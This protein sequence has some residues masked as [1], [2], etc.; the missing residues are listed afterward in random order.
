MSEMIERVA[1][2]LFDARPDRYKWDK[3]KPVLVSWDE[4]IEQNYDSVRIFRQYARI[5]IDAMHEPTEAMK[6]QAVWFGLDPGVG[7]N[8]W[9][10]MIDVAITEKL[11]P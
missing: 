9:K 3:Q 1:R 5:A 4:A 2:A 10:E 11:K 8:V 6:T 7:E